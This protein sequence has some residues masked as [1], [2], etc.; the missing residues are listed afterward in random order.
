MLPIINGI[1]INGLVKPTR[2][3]PNAYRL[4]DTNRAFI[5]DNVRFCVSVAHSKKL[6]RYR[7]AYIDYLI[8]HAQEHTQC[9]A[10]ME[11]SAPLH[12]INDIDYTI[13]SG[14]TFIKCI[15]IIHRLHATHFSDSLGD[16]FDVN[17]YSNFGDSL[18]DPAPLTR[19]QFRDQMAWALLKVARFV[20]GKTPL[21]RKMFAASPAIEALFKHCERC[22]RHIQGSEARTYAAI[23]EEMRHPHT[24]YGKRL[25]LYNILK[26]RETDAYYSIGAYSVISSRTTNPTDRDRAQAFF[27]NMGMLCKSLVDGETKPTCMIP[28]HNATH[29]TE[30]LAKYLVR[31][32]P[33]TDPLHRVAIRVNRR[34]KMVGV[35]DDSDMTTLRG[36]LKLQSLKPG[37]AFHRLFIYLV[38]HTAYH[39]NC[40]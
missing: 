10:H 1:D 15:A 27:D 34:R 12:A 19:A 35:S 2:Q 31:M 6:N 14:S 7:R 13:T 4:R 37:P 23:Y 24:G 29:V 22:D 20:T 11:G 38:P 16:V 36:L 8:A 5:W 25:R 3:Q 18:R 30:R 40:R 9:T 39:L 33:A 32:L 28:R 26:E 17:L 21:K